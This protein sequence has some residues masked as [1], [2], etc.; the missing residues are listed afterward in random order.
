MASRNAIENNVVQVTRMAIFWE[1]VVEE[2]ARYPRDR[3]RLEEPNLAS[4]SGAKVP[5]SLRLPDG[6]MPLNLPG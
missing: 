6:R 4:T 1:A 2:E 5:A 3:D